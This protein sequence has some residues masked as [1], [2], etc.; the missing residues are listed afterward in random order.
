MAPDH[1]DPQPAQAPQAPA[2]RRNGLTAT[3]IAPPNSL[4][5]AMMLQPTE[6]QPRQAKQ[7]RD[8]LNGTHAPGRPRWPTVMTVFR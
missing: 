2:C 7:L 6:L 4:R 3:P 8:S 5:P 1:R